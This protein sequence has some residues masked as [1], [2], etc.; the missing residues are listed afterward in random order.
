[1][2]T[3]QETEF[4]YQTHM[5]ESARGPSEINRGTKAR[6]K[7]RESA[8]ERISQN[9]Q[10]SR[11][12]GEIQEIAEKSA[13]GD[14]IYR[15][16]P[17]HYKK[18]SS[19]LYREHPEIETEHFD[20]EVVQDEILEE[21]KKF[22]RETD[23]FA[24]LTELQHY[25]Y[26]TNLIDFTTDCHIALF[27]ACYRDFDKDGR[28]VLLQKTNSCIVEPRSPV[29]RIIAQKSI[30]V[31]PPEGFIKPDHVINIPKDLKQ[32]ILD[33]LRNSHG[34]SIE[35]VYNDLHGFIRYQNVHQSAYAEFYSGL[36][37]QNE[38][39]YPKAIEHYSKS[40][41]LNPRLVTA[42]NNR[43]SAYKAI[44]DVDRAIADYNK[45]IDLNPEYAGVYYNRGIA[46]RARGEF[47]LAIED[48]SKAI[49]LNP[50]YAD[51]YY[52]RGIAY[53]D[54]GEFDLAIE[55]YSKAIEL[56][57]KYA[58]AYSNRGIAYIDK[59]N[60]DR[61]IEDFSKAIE[62]NPEHTK[63]HYNRGNFYINKGEFDLAIKDYS[64]AIELN[65][66]YADAYYNR[67]MC[68]LHLK[69]WQEAKSDLT[70]AK[71]MGM[72]IIALFRITYRNGKDFEQRNRVKLPEDIAAML[73]P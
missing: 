41:E 24:I 45:A 15:G 31:R 2:N 16:E 71:S 20:I 67:G 19:S 51:A 23:D 42:Y 12:L 7:R 47:D 37:C 70:V 18:V 35:T 55:D 26:N 25:G 8:K 4:D 11:V 33:Y 39:D 22:T 61:A 3:T 54:K 28:I 17:E 48:F 69:D 66:K 60:F 1:M 14:Y 62:L 46:Y 68:W 32:S 65:P 73:T 34:I 58:D 38:Q 53:I 59:G 49:K 43:G 50:K 6:E 30:F 63:V 57:P 64:K 52:N 29:N 21:A 27:F 10:L 40:I 36:T 5:K 9:G 13:D 56:N 72:D 44:S